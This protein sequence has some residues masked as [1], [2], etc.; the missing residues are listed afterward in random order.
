[1]VLVTLITPFPVA[2]SG[3]PLIAESPDANLPEVTSV[4]VS[5]RIF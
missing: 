5:L 1:M 4:A 2:I 3:L